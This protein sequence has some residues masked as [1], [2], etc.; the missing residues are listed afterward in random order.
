MITRFFA[1]V[2]EL[3]STLAPGATLDAGCGEGETLVRL[4]PLLGSRIAA[5]DISAY[6]IQRV[7]ER[8]PNVEARTGSVAD[9]PYPDSS[10][11][12]VMCLEVIEHLDDP[13]AAAAE[14]ARVAGRDVVVSVPHEPYFRIGSLMRG[15]Y[16][17]SFGNHPEHV[18]HF[19]HR[20]L[21][22]LLNP[23]LDVQQIR[24]AFPWLI[25]HGC[26]HDR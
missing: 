6:S 23:I 1:E 19:N 10:F 3:V 13:T 26:V 20:R 25:A 24:S 5:I 14:L 7:R 4:E 8:L 9:L 11:D 16:L 21:E 12:L 18:N 15:K 22:A 17:R 2:R